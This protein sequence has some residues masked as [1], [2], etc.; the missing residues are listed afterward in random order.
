MWL[1]LLLLF[2]VSGMDP[3]SRRAVWDVIQDAKLG[4]AVVL[5]TH[6][7]YTGAWGGAGT[8]P[9]QTQPNVAVKYACLQLILSSAV[10]H[11]LASS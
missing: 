1:L 5:T 2:I 9:N 10:P 3:I 8:R 4:R 6:R 7:Y 11:I